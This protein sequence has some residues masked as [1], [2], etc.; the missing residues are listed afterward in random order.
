MSKLLLHLCAVTSILLITSISAQ[1]DT[2]GVPTPYATIQAAIDAAFAAGGGDV[3]VAIG[4]YSPLT[5]GESFPIVMRNGVDLISASV[6]WNTIINADKNS[7]DQ[8]RVIECENVTGPVRIEGFTITGAYISTSSVHDGAG[9]WCSDSHLNLTNCI[10]RDNEAT[11]AGGGALFRA[12]TT[13]ITGC[14][15][16]DNS[17]GDGGG[18]FATESSVDVIECTLYGND[19]D[20]DAGGIYL[21]KGSDLDMQHTIITASTGGMAVYCDDTQGAC[22]AEVGCCDIYG[23]PE[24]DWVDCLL[25]LNGTA[26]NISEDALFC[27][28][29]NRCLFLQDCSPCV[30]D[31]CVVIGAYGVRCECGGGP[32]VTQPSTW[33]SV[34]ALYR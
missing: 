28:P 29:D 16:L 12:S 1:A 31:S 18:I 26:G 33:S 19:C 4:E 2:F 15:F 14:A 9:L 6:P 25:G 20:Y 21:W 7:S 22:S 8:G 11:G 17:A 30:G 3:E 10:I 27:D 13:V 5:N 32:T 23:N 34:K 24:G